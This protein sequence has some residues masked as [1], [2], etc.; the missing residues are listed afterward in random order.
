MS[1][2]LLLQQAVS[3]LK[4]GATVESQ[5]NQTDTVLGPCYTQETPW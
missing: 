4:E 2:V 3:T 5:E 1:V